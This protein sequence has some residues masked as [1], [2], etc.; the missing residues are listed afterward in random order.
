M[1]AVLIRFCMLFGFL[2]F[3]LAEQSHAGALTISPV[4]L[5]MDESQKAISMTIKNDAP[6]ATQIQ[7]RVFQWQQ[8]NGN[9]R[10][11]ETEDIVI[12]PPFIRLDAQR[13]YNVRIFRK[14]ASLPATEK[15]YR[16]IIDEIP[17]PVDTRTTG[18]GVK[19][20][21][22]TSHPLFITPARAIASLSWAMK[23]D[24]Q[25]WYIS[26]RNDG[27]RHALLTEVYLIDQNTG[28]KTALKVNSVNGYI[29]GLSYRDYEI[30]QRQFTPLSGHRYQIEARVNGKAIAGRL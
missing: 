11:S 28:K 1:R 25:G 9:D 22:R 21:L 26:A 19:I 15:T 6:E 16:I 4:S 10:F 5:Q 12:S 7:L 18:E 29:L 27:V 14:S 3:I 20:S 2:P 23:R 30:D 17:Q 24:N 8:E 13:S